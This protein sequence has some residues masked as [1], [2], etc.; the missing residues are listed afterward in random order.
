MGLWNVSHVAW[1]YWCVST[2]HNEQ[3]FRCVSVLECVFV[4]VVLAS[5]RLTVKIAYADKIWLAYDTS[6]GHILLLYLHAPQCSAYSVQVHVNICLWCDRF[7]F[8]FL[9]RSFCLFHYVSEIDDEVHGNHSSA[10]NRHQNVN[11]SNSWCHVWYVLLLNKC[12]Q[13]SSSLASSKMLLLFWLIQVNAFT[14]K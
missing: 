7:R 2:H 4:C 3:D 8:H 13:N 9:F 6:Y 11:P 1:T 12:I 5:M 10:R 14:L